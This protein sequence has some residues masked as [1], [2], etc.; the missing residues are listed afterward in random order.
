MVKWK[1]SLCRSATKGDK[2]AVNCN[3]FAAVFF[4]MH[5]PISINGHCYWEAFEV[6]LLN[7]LTV[8]SLRVSDAYMRR[9]TMPSLVQIM[10]CCLV[11]AKPLSE[12]MLDIVNYTLGN[13]LLWN[14]NRNPYCHSR[15]RLKMPSGKCWPFCFGLNVLTCGI[16]LGTIRIYWHFL[17]FL[18]SVMV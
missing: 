15:N 2:D 17:S 13:K 5:K 10:A 9:Q 18:G 11:V 12:P 6:K 16:D 7:E 14:F 4:I 3:N 8:N 1:T